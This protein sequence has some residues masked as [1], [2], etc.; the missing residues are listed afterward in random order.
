M[1]PSCDIPPNVNISHS[2]CSLQDLPSDFAHLT[3]LH[4]NARDLRAKGKFDLLELLTCEHTLDVICVSES[5]FT[6]STW[7]SYYLPDYNHFAITRASRGGGGVSLFVHSSFTVSNFSSIQSADESVQLLKLHVTRRDFS[8]CVIAAYSNSRLNSSTLLDLL[9]DALSSPPNIPI[10]LAGDLNVNLLLNDDLANQYLSFM[11][12]KGLLC[13]INDATRPASNSCLDHIFVSPTA[14]TVDLSSFILQSDLFSDHYPTAFQ[15][16]TLR[17]VPSSPLPPGPSHTRIFSARNYHAFESSLLRV[18]WA[19]LYQCRDPDTAL[20]LFD[21]SLFNCYDSSFPLVPSRPVA[22]SK[23]PWFSSALRSERRTLEKKRLRYLRDKSD[24][25]LKDSYYSSLLTYRHNVSHSRFLFSQSQFQ[26]TRNPAKLWSLINK[27]CGRKISGGPPSSIT[28]PSGP[29]SS[30]SDIATHFADYFSNI[31]RLTTEHIP[32]PAAFSPGDILPSR[33]LYLPFRLLP[34]SPDSILRL[35]QGMK[36]N[37]RGARTRVPSKCLKLFLPLL[38]SQICHIF[39]L[40]ILSSSVPRD[41]KLS[42]VIPLLK[43]KGDP[44]SPANYRPIALASFLSK[45][46]EK[47]VKA[48]LERHLTSIQF[49][50]PA[51]YG[52]LRG[53]S[54]DLALCDINEYVTKHCVGGGGVLGCFLDVAKAFD[55]I[56]HDLFLNF[57]DYL[58]F[59]QETCRWFRSYLS[60]RLFA[61]H[62]GTST[63]SNRMVSMGVPQGS[64]LG[65]YIF[66]IYINFLLQYISRE[67]SLHAICYADD[68]TLLLPVSRSGLAA[69]F[70]LFSS[71]LTKLLSVFEGLRLVLNVEQVSVC[72][73]QEQTEQS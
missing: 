14:D 36:T 52:F 37:Y 41:F 12:S 63:S 34:V 51:Q 3:L 1:I 35:S 69:N 54:C 24:P 19:P 31:P 67:T 64:V 55:T 50:S 15:I 47:C 38:I 70:S 43:R 33:P 45:L 72:A 57:L 29:L 22:L 42:A 44:S 68:T 9:D 46:L 49:F 17:P 62:I 60:D 21:E 16:R 59:S 13:L 56:S 20:S 32:S 26:D 11:S 28:T 30:P 27:S 53:L 58:D 39:N 71:D 2:T 66:V 5:F 4:F 6:P 40:S 73:L 48:Q 7:S 25:F 61:V 18:D 8:A 23:S 65:P 10:C